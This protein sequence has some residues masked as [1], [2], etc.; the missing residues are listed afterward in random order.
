MYRLRRKVGFALPTT[1]KPICALFAVL[2]ECS[3]WKGPACSGGWADSRPRDMRKQII[4]LCI[5]KWLKIEE[6]PP[7]PVLL[8]Q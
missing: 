5:W 6:L 1:L 4:R 2:E 7:T 8:P 3:V